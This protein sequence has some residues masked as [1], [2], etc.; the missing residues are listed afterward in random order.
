M[1]VFVDLDILHSRR[2]STPKIVLWK[3]TIDQKKKELIHNIT[4]GSCLFLQ[5]T[6]LVGEMF[7]FNKVT[8]MI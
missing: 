4:R 7:P 8:I 3:R 6:D 5:V 1:N 2:K